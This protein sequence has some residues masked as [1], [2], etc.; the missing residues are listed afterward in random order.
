MA[1]ARQRDVDGSLAAAKGGGSVSGGGGGG[2]STK[3]G[4]GAQRDG[5][6][7]VAAARRLRRWRQEPFPVILGSELG[8]EK[9]R[10]RDRAS[11]LSGCP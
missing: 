1:A 6:S 4:G 9:E 10:E 2:G 5:G 11:A 8:D 3:R 7:L